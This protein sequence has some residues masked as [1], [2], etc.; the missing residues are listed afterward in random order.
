MSHDQHSFALVAMSSG[1]FAAGWAACRR[2][3][4]TSPSP[5]S[6]RYI[7]DGDAR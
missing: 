6:S 2:R 4:R 5:L 7:V 3:S 1:F